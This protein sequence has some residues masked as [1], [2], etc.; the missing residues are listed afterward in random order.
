MI[1]ADI[2]EPSKSSYAAP[3]F[4]IPKKQK[5]EYRFLVDFRKLN[6]QTVNDRHPIPRSQDIFRALEGAKYFLNS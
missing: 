6:E 3:I 5:G 2:I 4:L 1:N